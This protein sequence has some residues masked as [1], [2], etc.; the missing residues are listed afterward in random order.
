MNSLKSSLYALSFVALF[1]VVTTSCAGGYFIQFVR[2]AGTFIIDTTIGMAIEELLDRYVFTTPAKKSVST[3]NP[4]GVI[5]YSP[6]GLTG[7]INYPLKVEIGGQRHGTSTTDF[8]ISAKHLQ[9]QR[10]SPS[11]SWGFSPDSQ[12][13]V[14][15]RVEVASAQLSLKDLGYNPGRIDGIWGPRTSD[16]VLAYQKSNNYLPNTGQLDDYTVNALLM[17]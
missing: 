5:P 7:Y 16:A 14:S 8:F 17:K 9:F 10:N 11:G 15:E 4:L 3:D 6:N 1:S 13:L 2:I 12:K